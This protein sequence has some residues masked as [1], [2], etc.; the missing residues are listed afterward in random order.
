MFH[1]RTNKLHQRIDRNDNS[2]IKSRLMTYETLLLSHYPLY[3]CISPPASESFKWVPSSPFSDPSDHNRHNRRRPSL[4]QMA[5][6]LLCC[7]CVWVGRGVV[8]SL[9]GKVIHWHHSNGWGAS[10]SPRHTKQLLSKAESNKHSALPLSLCVC[11]VGHLQSSKSPLLHSLYCSLGTLRRFQRLAGRER[12]ERGKWTAP[13]SRK[14]QLWGE[15][16]SNTEE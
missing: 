3:P 2:E 11:K 10:L 5:F 16:E 13:K 4:L 12:E 14:R 15:R 1:L 6:S 9:S 8:M 7:V